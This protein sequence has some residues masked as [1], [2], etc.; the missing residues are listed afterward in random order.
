MLNEIKNFFKKFRHRLRY[1]KHY[2]IIENEILRC[3]QPKVFF[4]GT[5]EY[6]NLGDQAICLAILNLLSKV[7]P[8]DSIFE[9]PTSI[10]HNYKEDLQSLIHETDTIYTIGGGNLGNLYIW[11]EKLRRDIISRFRQNKIVIM[12]QS[13]YFTPND[14]GTKELQIS[15]QIYNGHKHLHLITRDEISCGVAQKYF[16]N[17]HIHL[18]PDSV[19]ALEDEL[20]L[21]NAE[22]EGVLF[23]LRKDKEKVL[24]AEQIQKITDTLDKC[25]IPYRFN[26]TLVSYRVDGQNRSTEV[27]NK[28]Q[29]IRNAQLVI[30]DRFHGVIF[31]VITHT[32]VIAF[33]S[34]DTKISAGIKWFSNLDFVHYIDSNNAE[35][36]DL[37]TSCLTG[38]S[39][40][41][42]VS[43]NY[44]Q[45]LL[46][47]LKEISTVDER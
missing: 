34:F 17:I 42:N 9:I 12:P 13:I 32:P 27:I 39:N 38:A 43:N 44:K 20:P 40:N 18:L 24:P 6:G 41:S 3:K 23:L 29:A 1:R 22:R 36:A 8:A 21:T 19:L 26:D 45:L 2:K 4:I 10:Y 33:K 15:R 16:D 11:E 14:L 5:P 46:E 7:Y 28:I 31:S 25:N 47:K 30:T 35:Y 37:I